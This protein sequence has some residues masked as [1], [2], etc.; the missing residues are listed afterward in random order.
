MNYELYKQAYI[1]W[2]IRCPSMWHVFTSWQPEFSQHLEA[3][4][5]SHAQFRRWEFTIYLEVSTER[6]EL[7]P[8]NH[9]M[10]RVV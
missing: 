6:P 7:F 8:T 10:K 9:P 2:L 1:D 5:L 3:R 4:G